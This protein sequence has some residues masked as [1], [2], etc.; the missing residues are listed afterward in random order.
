MSLDQILQHLN[1]LEGQ[2]LGLASVSSLARLNRLRLLAR[3]RGDLAWNLTGGRWEK[4]LVPG[5][6]QDVLPACSRDFLYSLGLRGG[7]LGSMGRTGIIEHGLLELVW[8]S[9]WEYVGPD[10]SLGIGT[11]AAV[12]RGFGCSWHAKL[13]VVLVDH[14]V[15]LA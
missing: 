5:V 9:G 8:N 6:V 3:L 12:G 14:G 2:W 10:R 13:Q 4:V 1:I 11:D 15:K 7:L